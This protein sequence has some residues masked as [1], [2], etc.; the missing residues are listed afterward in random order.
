M[1]QRL[2]SLKTSISGKSQEEVM[3]SDEEEDEDPRPA[4][5]RRID[6][7]DHNTIS[8]PRTSLVLERRLPLDH[9]TNG[10]TRAPVK[11]SLETSPLDFYAKS[12]TLSCLIS[13][14]PNSKKLFEDSK[15][16]IS[17]FLPKEPHNFKKS[18]RVDFG[19]IE[20]TAAF[21]DQHVL[22]EG[23][24]LPFEMKCRCQVAIFYGKND[25]DPGEVNTKAFSEL[26]RRAKS[27]TIRVS[28]GDN[29]MIV[30]KLIL[31]EPFVFSPDEFYVDRKLR[32]PNGQF[33]AADEYE[34]IVGFADLYRMQV[35]I[36]PWGGQRERKAW[37]L[38]SIPPFDENEPRNGIS[39]MLDQGE[40]KK[41]SLYLFSQTTSML[42]P[43]RSGQPQA[44]SVCYRDPDKG[45]ETKQRLSYGL[46]FEIGWALPTPFTTVPLIVREV[47]TPQSAV[48]ELIPPA[49]PVPVSPLARVREDI[50]PYN[51]PVDERSHRRRAN[52]PTYNLKALSAQAQGKSPRKSRDSRSRSEQRGSE[53]E[54]ISVTYA[55][56]KEHA[57]DLGMKSHTTVSG[58]KC[59]FCVYRN[60]S[61]DDLKLH[62]NTEHSTFTFRFRRGLPRVQFFVD[63]PKLS[64][65][66]TIR[67]PLRTFQLCK[68]VG[69]FDLERYLSGDES[70]VK[71]RYGPQHNLFPDH[72]MP[73]R[74]S[75]PSL[76]SS[77]HDS[78]HSSPN[79]SN[80]TDSMDYEYHI[81]KPH[82]RERRVYT[83]PKT[84]RP[85][86]D[87]ITKQVL[88]EG[89]EL[90]DSDSEKDEEWLIQRKIDLLND[91]SDVSAEEKEYSHRWNEFILGEH[92]TCDLFIPDAIDRFIEANKS[93]IVETISHQQEF[94]KQ[95]GGFKLRGHVDNVFMQK[96]LRT[97]MAEKNAMKGEGKEKEKDDIEMSG[98]EKLHIGKPR[99]PMEC[100]CGEMPQ[101]P[102]RMVCHGQVSHQAANGAMCDILLTGSQ[103]C[104]FRNFH[105]ACAEKL[106]R[107]LGNQ[108]KCNDCFS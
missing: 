31:A 15:T 59:P 11:R 38:L 39:E 56:N 54:E 108:W 85:L 97:L 5:R 94:W 78:R 8:S 33:A 52:V 26:C 20:S 74:A 53:N 16:S 41:D 28:R 68:P 13:T 9:V 37:P 7:P 81:P 89:D 36:G 88:H 65:S 29:G 98:M 99:G 104:K 93:W 35:F 66:S 46:N 18:L 44:I 17:S 79:T 3:A 103:R 58:L 4:K 80:F 90:S 101:G 25:D 82:A 55:F 91:F 73:P 102:H 70:W 24:E 72:L 10:S 75:D 40:I 48:A 43:H 19:D 45:K 96:C 23:Q 61:L 14:P 1:G 22:F 105:K 86:Y 63:F 49:P 62:L 67:D 69:L 64:T 2:S 95:L 92:L 60:T 57:A 12:K 47:G 42:S 27:C 100:V 34:T 71:N 106:G 30:R 6:Q 107:P 87:T 51:S 77:P 50:S 32:R 76:S 21:T 84:P 83:I